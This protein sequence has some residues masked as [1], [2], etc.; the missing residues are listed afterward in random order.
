MGHQ[1]L[2]GPV[3][4]DAEAVTGR[5]CLRLHD[6]ALDKAV[7]SA[8]GWRGCDV[9]RKKTHRPPCSVLPHW[10]LALASDEEE[11]LTGTN[12]LG[13]TQPAMAGHLQVLPGDDGECPIDVTGRTLGISDV[14]MTVV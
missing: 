7:G 5:Q 14:A 6:V 4:G 12:T 11:F 1:V 13:Q 2:G 3:P 8:S 10:H 9:P